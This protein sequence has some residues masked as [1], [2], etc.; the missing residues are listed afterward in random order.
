MTLVANTELHELISLRNELAM[1]R[2]R[3]QRLGRSDLEHSIVNLERHVVDLICETGDQGHAN[4][5]VPSNTLK[6]IR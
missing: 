5:Q 6:L 4:V 2:D 1:A 3:A